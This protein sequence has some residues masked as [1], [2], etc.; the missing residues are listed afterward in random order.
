MPESQ[1]LQRPKG[2]QEESIPSQ[3]NVSIQCSLKKQLCEVPSDLMCLQS[4]TPVGWWQNKVK[5]TPK[6]IEERDLAG[7]ERFLSLDNRKTTHVFQCM[8]KQI[9]L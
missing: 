2:I 7:G 1:H 8:W 9:P 4:T 6:S 3:N 5:G